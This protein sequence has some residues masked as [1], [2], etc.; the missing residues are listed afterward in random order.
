MHYTFAQFATSSKSD[1]RHIIDGKRIN[2]DG[3][4]NQYHRFC[5][6][7]TLLWGIM[8]SWMYWNITKK[9]GTIESNASVPN[10]KPPTVPTPTEMNVFTV[11]FRFD[12]EANLS[13]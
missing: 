1:R 8:R 11:M 10:T 12:F 7:F 4:N 6:A 3:T 2:T 5:I 9:T 13:Y